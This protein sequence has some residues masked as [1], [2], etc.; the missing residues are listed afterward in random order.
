M[1]F[2]RL[3]ANTLLAAGMAGIVGLLGAWEGATYG[4]G[5]PRQI[6]AAVFP[7]VL[8]L[9]LVAAACGIVVERLVT[10]EDP[11]EKLVTVPTG[12]L[13]GVLGGPIAFALIIDRFGLAPAV[14]ACVVIASLADRTLK[15]LSVLLLACGMAALCSLV[16]ISLLSLP[17][18]IVSW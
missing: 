16:F 5:T 15:P 9:L 1:T 18:D 11:D 6:G 2:Q 10:G 3:S 12:V 4:F 7:F 14:I 13:L 17:I 8:S